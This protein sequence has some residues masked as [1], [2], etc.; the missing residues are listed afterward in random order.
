MSVMQVLSVVSHVMR[1]RSAIISTLMY[2]LLI[3]IHLPSY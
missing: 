3:D 2:V 1:L